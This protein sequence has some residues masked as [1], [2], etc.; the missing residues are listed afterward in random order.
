MWYEMI[1]RILGRNQ[2][3]TVTH[4]CT[5]CEVYLGVYK[6]DNLHN[7]SAKDS[8][9]TV[10]TYWFEGYKRMTEAQQIILST[11]MVVDCRVKLVDKN[12]TIARGRVV[13]PEDA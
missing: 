9:E 6:G 7:P 5:T 13:F 1:I 3:E 8:N 4:V 12:E 10:I 2:S 11:Y